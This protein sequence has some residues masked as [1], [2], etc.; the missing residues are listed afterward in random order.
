MSA[1]HGTVALTIA[2]L[3][4][5]LMSGIGIFKHVCGI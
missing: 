5:Q 3:T 1:W 2:L 4:V